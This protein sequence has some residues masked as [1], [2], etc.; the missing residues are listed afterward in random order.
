MKFISFTVFLFW[1]LSS[2]ALTLKIST[3]YPDGTFPINELRKA[4]KEIE[5]KTEGRVKLR[6]YPGGVMGS[7]QVT[8]RKIRIGQLHGF[9]IN[10][11]TLSH[12]HRDSQVYNAPLFFKNFEQVDAVRKNMDDELEEGFL[13]S[14]WQ[15]FGLIES[16]FVYPMSS[17]RITSIEDLRS[18][19]LWLPI[20][21]PIAQ[22]LAEAYSVPAIY[23]SIGD[24]LTALQTGAVDTIIAPPIGA[25]S[26]QWYTKV[27]YL[28]DL[29]FMYS[30]SLLAISDKHMKKLSP[31]DKV[32]V[33]DA[34]RR[35][36]RI[37]DKQNRLDNEQA[38]E[39]LLN[40]GV[41]LVTLTD[42]EQQSIT[43]NSIPATKKLI[44]SGE[45]SDEL[46]EKMKS[47]VAQQ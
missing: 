13:E 43:E 39:A 36:C 18:A 1:S 25:I 16:G 46:F 24:V 4:S 45:F 40:Q 23:L 20:N 31:N 7:D 8:M 26:L 47:I 34:L 21:D 12:A 19:K 15:T 33:N 3:L 9:L 42:V 28:I 29:P 30:Y 10:G 6:V 5:Q 11:G 14:G 2:S 17:K 38:F 37:I 22:K 27:D 44:S 35:V 32:I 41:E